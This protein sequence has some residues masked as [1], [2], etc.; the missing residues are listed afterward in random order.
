MPD[1]VFIIA[2]TSIISVTLL[3]FGALRTI[4]GHL[5]RKLKAQQGGE[6]SGQVLVELEDLR[7]R[8]EGSDEL[9]DRLV[10]M[11]ERLDFAERML[12]EGKRDQLRAKPS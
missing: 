8:L 9:R 12:T 7:S 3:G 11:E 2:M 10:D 5:A 4:S 1:E 6:G